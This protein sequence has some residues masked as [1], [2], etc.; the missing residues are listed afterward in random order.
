MKKILFVVGLV[1]FVAVS[2][3]MLPCNQLFALSGC[4]KERASV[5]S[6]WGK[7]GESFRTCKS[8]NRTKDGDD[9]F[10]RQGL[11]WWDVR[12]R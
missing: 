12:C 5:R 9:V 10:D 2:S 4:C 8:L 7:N 11:V 6:G 1:F 3:L